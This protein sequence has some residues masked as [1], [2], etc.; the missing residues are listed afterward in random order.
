MTL[1]AASSN[2][3]SAL[4]VNEA[5]PPEKMQTLSTRYYP[6]PEQPRQRMVMDGHKGFPVQH[7]VWVAPRAEQVK[8]V[9]GQD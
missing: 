8:A 6:S 1:A 9:T 3:G 4:P 7:D 2:L 5:A